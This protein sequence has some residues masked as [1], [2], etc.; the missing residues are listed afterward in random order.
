VDQTKIRTLYVDAEAMTIAL[1]FHLVDIDRVPEGMKP[2]VKVMPA[3]QP[4]ALPEGKLIFQDLPKCRPDLGGYLTDG[5]SM[6]NAFVKYNQLSGP[7][8]RYVARF[9]FARSGSNKKSVDE[10]V[11][12][13]RAVELA[14]KAMETLS[15]M[16]LW[17]ASLHKNPF[18]APKGNFHGLEINFRG[19]IPLFEPDGEPVLVWSR[20]ERGKPLKGQGK[21]PLEPSYFLQ[22]RDKR[23]GISPSLPKPAMASA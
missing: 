21:V 1:Q 10:F 2:F 13:P 7:A 16:A 4:P 14:M 22:A 18:A 11:K 8:S 17:Q 19:R 3:V 12:R 6:I 15:A 9:V 5:W 20:N 23:R